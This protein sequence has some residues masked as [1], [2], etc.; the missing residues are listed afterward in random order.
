MEDTSKNQIDTTLVLHESEKLNSNELTEKYNLTFTNENDDNFKILAKEGENQFV[1]NFKMSDYISKKEKDFTTIIY[2]FKLLLK[3]IERA[4]EKNKII[5]S[6]NND[7]LKLTFHYENILDEKLIS[8][9]LTNILSEKK[10]EGKNEDTKLDEYLAEIIEYNNKFEENEDSKIIR[11][12]VENKGNHYWIKGKTSFKCAQELSSLLCR[13]YL[14]E[15]YVM[16]GEQID[17]ILDFPKNQKVNMKHNYVTSLYLSENQQKYGPILKIDL[18]EA[19]KET[20]IF[21]GED[22]KENDG[23]KN[24]IDDIER[25]NSVKEKIDA[26]NAKEKERLEKEKN[27]GFIKLLKKNIK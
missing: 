25:T 26:L 21:K 9:E 8:F 19:I 14:L 23:Q 2:N 24:E 12:T 1:S 6:K 4:L 22:K 10:E 11:A 20:D 17:I 13:D 15:E 27:P 16:P 5:L 3:F 18:R 7:S